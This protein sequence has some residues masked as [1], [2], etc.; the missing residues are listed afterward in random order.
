VCNVIII[1]SLSGVL[2]ITTGNIW[3]VYVDSTITV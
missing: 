3:A 1:P 2:K